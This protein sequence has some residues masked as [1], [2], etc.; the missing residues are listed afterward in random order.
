MHLP[1]QESSALAVSAEDLA[2]IPQLRADST[3]GRGWQR[4][5]QLR[6]LTYTYSTYLTCLT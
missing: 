4:R 5:S 3:W 1:T 2:S 6:Y